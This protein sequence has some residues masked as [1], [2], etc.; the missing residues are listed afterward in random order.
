MAYEIPSTCPA[1]GHEMQA[2]VLYCPNCETQVSGDFAL[3]RF[4]H[5]APEQLAFLEVFLKCRGNLKDVGVRLGM[6]YP[7]TRSRLD[8]LLEVLGY[9]E[10]DGDTSAEDA[11]PPVRR[12]RKRASAIVSTEADAQD[13]QAE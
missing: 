1:C 6:S 2:R 9:A 8:S 12:G 13:E 7:T 5:L 10:D 4:S 11:I 3:G